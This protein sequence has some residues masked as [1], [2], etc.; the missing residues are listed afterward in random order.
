MAAAWGRRILVPYFILVDG[1]ISPRNDIF[2]R[3]FVR[4]ILFRFRHRFE[5]LV[6]YLPSHKS[7]EDSD[8][9]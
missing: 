2:L 4:Q 8:E 1:I 6:I 9:F 3:L 7:M 5:Y